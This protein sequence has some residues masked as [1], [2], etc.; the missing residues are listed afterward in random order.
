MR[1]SKSEIKNTPENK[2]LAQEVKKF[3]EKY[4]EE[5]DK[6]FDTLYNITHN[7]EKLFLTLSSIILTA[8]FSFIKLLPQADF[9]FLLLVGWISFTLAIG[10][11]IWNQIHYR[12]AFF[13]KSLNKKHFLLWKINIFLSRFKIKSKTELKDDD[14]KNEL[15]LEKA[16]EDYN[17]ALSNISISLNNAQLLFLSGIFCVL[18]F[19]I[20][21]FTISDY[22]KYPV[23]VFIIGWILILFKFLK[24]PLMYK[25]D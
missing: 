2:I 15:N 21:N 16:T 12:H 10:A 22:L 5:F 11:I 18:G 17:T 6:E 8:S 13:D 19:S 1:K 14:T 9:K 25:N 23:L 24:K 4:F 20:L 3:L 7:S